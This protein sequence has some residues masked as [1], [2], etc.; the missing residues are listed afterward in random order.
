MKMISHCERE[1]EEAEEDVEEVEKAVKV[2]K[3]KGAKVKAVKGVMDHTAMAH[4][5][6]KPRQ[7][8]H[9]WS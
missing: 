1:E 8:I 9:F 5:L 6:Y 2:A 3:V 4:H 7:C